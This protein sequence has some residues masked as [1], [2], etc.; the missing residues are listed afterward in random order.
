[1]QDVETEKRKKGLIIS[2]LTIMES[3]SDEM[4]N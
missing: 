1:M 3:E 2:P 4:K